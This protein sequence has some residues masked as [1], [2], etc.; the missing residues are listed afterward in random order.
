LAESE[1]GKSSP[2]TA[3]EKQNWTAKKN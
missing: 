1:I 3:V 2:I